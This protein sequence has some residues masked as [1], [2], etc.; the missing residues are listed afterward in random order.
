VTFQC[1]VDG[2]AFSPCRSPFTTRVSSAPGKGKNH[3]ISIKQ[4]DAAGNQ[5]G[6]VR[7]FRFRVVLKD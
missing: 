3:N 1:S 4:V 6:N 2:G 7:V 5:V